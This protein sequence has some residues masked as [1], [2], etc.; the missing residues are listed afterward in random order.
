MGAV[1]EAFAGVLA[2]C[3]MGMLGVLA[4]LMLVEDVKHLANEIAAS[5][6]PYVL[7]DRDQLHPG[8]GEFAHVEFGVKSVAAETAQRVNDDAIERA[9]GTLRLEDH[10]LE[11]RAV[12][13]KG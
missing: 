5:V 11:D 13:I 8:F 10:F 4:G 2:H 7:R 12:L 6:M 1:P 3:S 9:V